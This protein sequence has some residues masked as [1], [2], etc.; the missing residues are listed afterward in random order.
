[1]SPS[2]TVSWILLPFR[3]LKEIS[4]FYRTFEEI[5]HILP[6]CSLL[7]KEF[8]PIGR[9][10]ADVLSSNCEGWAICSKIW[11]RQ[12]WGRV[13]ISVSFHVESCSL[14][15]IMFLE[16]GKNNNCSLETMV[17]MRLSGPDCAICLSEN[18]VLIG[19]V[20]PVSHSPI[21]LAIYR[22]S[23]FWILRS[24]QFSVPKGKRFDANQS[25][26]S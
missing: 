3:S 20:W 8:R 22:V 26:C 1:M 15:I 17:T 25:A 9:T 23:Y 14:A 2:I 16:F 6:H 19:L 5:K 13:P 12:K 21:T 4:T 11:S 7:Q 10:H 18:A 24:F